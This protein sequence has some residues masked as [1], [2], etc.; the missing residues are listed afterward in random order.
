MG[1]RIHELRA[2][3]DVQHL[4]RPHLPND[5]GSV[6]RLSD[7][8]TVTEGH[9][10]TMYAEAIAAHLRAAG[11]AVLTNP[12]LSGFYSA[13]QRHAAE[14][15]AHVYLACHVNAGGGA[16]TLAEYAHGPGD[17]A[18]LCRRI[19]SSLAD[20]IAGLVSF[21]VNELA[22][23]A[24]GHACVAGFAGTHALLEPFFGDNPQ[25]QPL[26]AA[27]K[28]KLIGDVIGAAVV[29]WWTFG[30]DSQDAADRP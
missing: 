28:L 20:N 9:A 10:A 4:Y 18:G 3:V 5:R 13:R 19:A 7:G 25:H 26:L 6:Y 17:S 2:A 16:Y 23:D 8:S 30:H 29:N 14:W 12:D 1:E 15:G 24:R 11:A 27:P 21:S 22:P